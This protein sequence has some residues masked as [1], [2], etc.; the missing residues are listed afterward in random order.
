MNYKANRARAALKLGVAVLLL[1]PGLALAHNYNYLE[2]GYLHRDQAGDE[3]GF[4]VAGSFDIL[5]PIA[6]FAEYG[7]VDNFSQLSIGGLWHT[8]LTRDLDLNLGA[9]LEQFDHDHGGDDTGFGL[10]AGLRWAVPNTR[11]ELN[12]ELRYVDIDN[13]KAD[14]VSLRLGALYALTPALDLEGGVQGGEDDRFDVG[15]RYNFGPRL[16]GR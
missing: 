4:R 7:D 13:D 16:S 11:L 2:G 14:G 5:S 8:P 15:L 6:V 9:S 12:P 3:D 10:R 1:A